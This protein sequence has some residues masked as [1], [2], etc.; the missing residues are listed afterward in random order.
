MKNYKKKSMSALMQGS[1]GFVLLFSML[2]CFSCERSTITPPIVQPVDTTTVDIPIEV[3]VSIKKGVG[4][5]TNTNIGVWWKNLVNLKVH[6]FY[7]WGGFLSDAQMENLPKNVEF[8][9]MAWN[10]AA[11]TEANI[12]RWNALYEEGK[13][14]YLLGFNEPD[15]TDE[16]NMSVELAIERWTFLCERINPGIKLISPVTSYPSL[17]ETSWMVRFMNEVEARDLRVDYIGVH[18]YNPPTVSNFTTPLKNV[19]ERWGKK[20]WLTEL[21]VRDDNT[22]GVVAN[23]RYTPAQMLSFTQALLP[24]LEAMEGIDRYAWFDSPPH[25]AGL[26]PCALIDGNGLPTIVGEYYR[27]LHPNE[28]IAEAK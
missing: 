10:G 4:M 28:E 18:I 20:I 26:W 19:Y 12:A 17:T 13:I 14:N 3:K 8:V 6:W 5:S 16:A 21:G 24:E 2:F 15:L 27:D 1:L 25:F 9:P 11:V 22:G 7:T 23:N